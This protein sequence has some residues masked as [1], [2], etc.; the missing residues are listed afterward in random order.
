MCWQRRMAFETTVA[1]RE[2]GD[3]SSYLIAVGLKL[4][5]VSCSQRT[6]MVQFTQIFQIKLSLFVGV[7]QTKMESKSVRSVPSQASRLFLNVLWQISLKYK[8]EQYDVTLV[9]LRRT[10]NH[11]QFLCENAVGQVQLIFMV[12]VGSSYRQHSVITNLNSINVAL[13]CRVLEILPQ[14]TNYSHYQD[15]VLLQYCD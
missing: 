6:T 13:S 11:R 9:Y 1:T 7:R 3:F 8:R 12:K 10:P 15:S 4:Q 2:R 14:T 5:P